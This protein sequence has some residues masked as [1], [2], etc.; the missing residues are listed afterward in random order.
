MSSLLQD[1]VSSGLC[2]CG[3]ARTGKLGSRSME[4]SASVPISASLVSLRDFGVFT[5]DSVAQMLHK[6]W[7]RVPFPGGLVLRGALQR[8]EGETAS[9]GK[10][11]RSQSRGC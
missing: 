5:G 2:G 9:G 4:P 8:K 11:K 1:R 10:P 3:R 7:T 6:S